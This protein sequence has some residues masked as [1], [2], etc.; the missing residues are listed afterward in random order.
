MPRPGTDI[1]ISEPSPGG[2]GELDTGQAFMIGVADRGPTERPLSV[3][4]LSLWERRFGPRAGGPVAHNSVRA[5]FTER[6]SNLQFLRL[7]GANATAAEAEVGDLQV[8]ANSPGVWG[9]GVKVA[10]VADVSPLLAR[11]PAPKTRAKAKAMDDENGNG[12]NGNGETAPN[13]AAAGPFRLVVTEGAEIVERSRQVRT[14]GD[15][16]SWARDGSD[17]LTLGADPADEE[18][19]LAAV[20]ATALT[21]GRDDNNIT[22]TVVA[23]AL[24]RFPYSMGFAQVLY[25]GATDYDVHAAILEHCDRNRRPALLDL[26][27]TDA[28]TIA[29]DA[30]ALQGI[31]G[32]RFAA[33]LAPRIVYPGPVS[34]TTTLIPYSAA[35][36]GMIARADAATNN[37]NEAAAGSNGESLAARGIAVDFD[38]DT[39]ELLN[40]LGVTLPRMMRSGVMRTYGTRTV[41]GPNDTNWM[42]FPGSRTVLAMA[43]EF[44]NAAEE[45]VHRQIDGQRRL[46]TRLEVAL[47]G[48]CLEWFGMGA[49]YG[50]EPEDAFSIDTQSVNTTETIAAGEVHAIVRLRT[51][52][53]GEWVVIEIQKTPI[54]QS[55]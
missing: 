8:S 25:P 36:A 33:A 5:F 38:D 10:I 16:L 14:V 7:A 11:A 31:P 4:S 44:D 34:G 39:R 19:A 32:S 35:Q 13:G 42:W 29:A 51:S 28:A 22:P 47:G 30:N 54:T 20:A 48:I 50:D 41:A 46:F 12:S 55:V 15:A 2:G 37:P 17:Y 23:G 24:S 45:F 52:P 40:E 26:N 9:N 18:K 1:L 43:H 49:L 3:G 21:T 27:D 6:G 53:P